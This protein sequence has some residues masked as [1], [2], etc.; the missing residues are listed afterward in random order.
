MTPSLIK[1]FPVQAP[2]AGRRFVKF[3]GVG[4]QIALAV[5]G[6]S[7]IGV[8]DNMGALNAGDLCDVHQDGLY[9]VEAGAAFAAGDMLTADSAGRAIKAV[10]NGT[11]PVT[12]FARANG[13]AI[14]A[15][16]FIPAIISIYRTPLGV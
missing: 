10:A 11:T 6:D 1:S 2:I 7:G 4:N 9:E 12:I 3:T 14:A 5:A 8:S 13:A 15:G 16:D